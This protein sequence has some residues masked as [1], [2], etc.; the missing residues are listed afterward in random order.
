MHNVAIDKTAVTL[1]KRIRFV[2]NA[3]LLLSVRAKQKLYGTV[4]VQRCIRVF[5]Y[6]TEIKILVLLYVY[7]IKAHKSSLRYTVNNLN[8]KTGKLIRRLSEIR[9]SKSIILQILSFFN[10]KI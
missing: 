6:V 7:F 4:K 8:Y 9:I 10:R 5:F 1:T 3:N 2:G